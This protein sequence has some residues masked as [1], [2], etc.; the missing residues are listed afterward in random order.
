MKRTLLAL[1]ASALIILAGGRSHR[2]PRAQPARARP[3]RYGRIFRTP[4]CRKCRPWQTNG[5]PQ[6][7]YRQIRQHLSTRHGRRISTVAGLLQLK[8]KKQ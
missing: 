8:A 2:C 6:R 3:L 1:A 7:R 5:H 4:R